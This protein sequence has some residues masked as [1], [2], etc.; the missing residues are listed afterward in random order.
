MQF[1]VIGHDGTD[2][3]ALQR[4][5][6]ARPAHI[7]LGD[8]LRDSG[9]MLYGVAMLNDSGNMCGSVLVCEFP[10]RME[11]DAWLKTEPY[12]TGNVW[13]KIEVIPC[14]VGPSFQKTRDFNGATI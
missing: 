14:K 10:S 4:R 7:Q 13:E 2:S 6:F 1:I 9:N 3:S 11:L 12:V 5:L 8:K